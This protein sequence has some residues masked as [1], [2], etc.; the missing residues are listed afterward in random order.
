MAWLTE[1]EFRNLYVT[2][3]AT[4]INSAQVESC[5]QKAVREIRKLAGAEVVAEIEAEQAD[6][7]ADKVLDFREA[8]EKLAYRQ[9]LLIWSS[10]FRS[11][12][13]MESETDN[14]AQSTDR[15]EKFSETE[16]RRAALYAEALDAISAYLPADAQGDSFGSGVE[17][18]HPTAASTTCIYEC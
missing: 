9:L 3:S 5:L 4:E 18:S 1:D 10:R 14:N 15:Y 11:G 16:K 12:G 7:T 8:Q 17:Y 2:E 13:V 6:S